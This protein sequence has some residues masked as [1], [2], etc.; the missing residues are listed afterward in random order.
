[1]TARGYKTSA[2]GFQY[3]TSR[4]IVGGPKRK[5]HKPSGANLDVENRFFDDNKRMYQLFSP[6]KST[7]KQEQPFKPR[8]LSGS[9]AA[10]KH[11]GH[12]SDETDKNFLH[13]PEKKPAA[14]VQTTQAPKVDASV[15]VAPVSTVSVQAPSAKQDQAISANNSFVQ[16]PA[17]EKEVKQVTR[18]VSA[19]V[20]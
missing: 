13:F 1:M 7:P 18:P 12:P 11:L 16:T 2:S 20:S 15:L 6:E 10:N 8:P 9:I 17:P 5:S 19:A 4:T 3:G 14:A